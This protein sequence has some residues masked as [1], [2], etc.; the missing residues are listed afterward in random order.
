MLAALTVLSAF[1]AGGY[2]E[3]TY[4]LLCAA[5]WLGIAGVAAVRPLSRPSASVW[6]LLAL[7][8]WTAL[9]ALWGPAG[10]ALRTWPLPALYAGI[11]FVAESA[12]G[13]MRL[14]R[15][16]IELVVLAAL[17]A[18][19]AGVAPTGGG[20]HSDRMSWPVTYANG[21]GLLAVLGVLLTAGL[22]LPRARLAVG[23]CAVLGAGA[24]LTFSRTALL[25]GAG[26][27]ALLVARRPDAA[28]G[29]AGACI[30]I[31][32]VAA[33]D[34]VGSTDGASLV[35][36]LALAAAA[37]FALPALRVRIPRRLALAGVLGLAVAAAFL[38]QPIAARF[39]APAPDS[40][41]A[42]RLLDVSGH[43]RADLWR[44]AWHEGAD[45]PLIG[46]GA[47][48]WPRAYATQ[49]HTLDGPANAHSLYLETFAEL[50]IVGLALLVA[51]LAAA[52]RGPPAAV[53]VVVAYVAAAAI[54]WDWQLPAVTIP[55][56]VAAAAGRV[57]RPL[58]NSLPFAALA[59]AVGVLAG[60]HGIGAAVVENGITTESQA[61]LAARLLPYDA[62]PWAFLYAATGS[63]SA[64]RRACGADA[65][66]L[67][68]KRESSPSGGCSLGRK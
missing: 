5:V 10:P 49:R 21:L 53:A 12:R 14:Q 65:G 22:E 62:R 2:Y 45:H 20:P 19:A 63:P 61:R 35:P 58:R 42:H 50:G 3:S 36:A 55:A 39:A 46:G 13:A 40:R 51:A 43:G 24:Y 28:R 15:F 26:A 68:L 48:S 9:S 57:R 16:A 8:A 29:I 37:A 33:L 47:G 64:L 6:L 23:A 32:S 56:L 7:A 67:T 34:A 54:D 44:T 41:D 38:A 66:D 52:V 17:V 11:L 31:A 4:S 1:L 30:G 25:V 60:L 27:A 18:R 59:L